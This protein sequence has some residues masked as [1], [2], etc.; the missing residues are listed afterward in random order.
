MSNGSSTSAGTRVAHSLASNASCSATRSAS[1]SARLVGGAGQLVDVEQPLLAP[2]RLQPQVEPGAAAGQRGRLAGQRPAQRAGQLGRVA[3]QQRP[4]GRPRAGRASR[5]P[6]RRCR[7]RAAGRA[8]RAAARA[9]CPTPS[10]RPARCGRTSGARPVRRR[11][12]AS[13]AASTAGA[14]ARRAGRTG[15]PAD[16][17]SAAIGLAVVLGRRV[18]PHRHLPAA[19]AAQLAQLV[20][21]SDGP[22]GLVRCPTSSP[23]RAAGR[24]PG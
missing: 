4:A 20:S 15:Q 23:S 7:G 3:A 21:R 5:P 10:T 8:R 22:R 9:R 6:H 13:A 19:A 2:P 12:P 14:G 1:G 17:G 16:A 18:G 24:G 11:A